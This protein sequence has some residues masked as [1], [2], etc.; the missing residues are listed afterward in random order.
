MLTTISLKVQMEPSLISLAEMPVDPKVRFQSTE[1]KLNLSMISIF[2]LFA[3]ISYPFIR[4][5]SLSVNRSAGW[6]VGQS[7]EVFESFQNLQKQ[8]SSGK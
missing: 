8:V 7:D 3:N 2:N 1:T 6:S 5:W 4:S